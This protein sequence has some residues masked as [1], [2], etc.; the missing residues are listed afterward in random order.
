[1]TT[2]TASW[3]RK[4]L[5]A[6]REKD[7]PRVRCR[8]PK[9][10]VRDGCSDECTWGN[11]TGYISVEGNNPWIVIHAA[12]EQHAERFSWGLVCQVLNDPHAAPIF[13]DREFTYEA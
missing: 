3:T 2:A 1:M 12:G 7:R 10:I 9:R 8:F 6:L 11:C 13:F 5:E 4:E